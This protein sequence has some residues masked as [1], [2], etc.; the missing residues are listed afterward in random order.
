MNI[1]SL[2]ERLESFRY[3]LKGL[4]ALITTQHNA[5]IHA[6]ST[7][8]VVSAGLFLCI[9]NDDWIRLILAVALVWVAEALNTAMEFLCDAAIPDFHPLVEKAKDVAA[10]AVFISALAAL[11][12]GVLIFRPYI[13]ALL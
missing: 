12:V 3:A 8:V 6:V 2:R 13:S 10:G 1:F 11:I 4:Y 5:W 9:S 7:V